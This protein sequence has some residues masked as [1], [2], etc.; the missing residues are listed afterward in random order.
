M[1]YYIFQTFI[2]FIKLQDFT[3]NHIIIA[4]LIQITRLNKKTM[5]WSDKHETN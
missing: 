4:F 3:G 1:I 5:L 2:V